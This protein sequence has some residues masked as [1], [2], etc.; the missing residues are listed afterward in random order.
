MT[1]K[2][3]TL[4]SRLMAGVVR[5]VGRVFRVS[6]LIADQSAIGHNVGDFLNLQC[7]RSCTGIPGRVWLLTSR[8]TETN[9][10]LPE[11]FRQITTMGRYIKPIRTPTFAHRLLLLE[12]WRPNFPALSGYSGVSG[13]EFDQV[14]LYDSGLAGRLKDNFSKRRV[15]QNRRKEI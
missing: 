4:L 10:E 12:S 6:I 8:L 9:L 7:A 11:Y 14:E 15:V 3:L 13:T 5:V 1:K 2:V